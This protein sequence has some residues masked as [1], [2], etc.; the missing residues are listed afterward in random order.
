MNRTRTSLIGCIAV[1]SLLLAG[2][3]TSTSDSAVPPP[4]GSV[5]GAANPAARPADNGGGAT[6]ACDL[7]TEQDAS[8]AI[9][10]PA[11]PG[12]PGG[13]AALSECIF[14]DGS[15]IVSMKRPGRDL[16]DSSRAQLQGKPFL[17]VPDVGDGGFSTGS[18]QH[19]TLE[20]VKG[21]TLVSILLGTTDP[22]PTDAIIALAKAAV[23]HL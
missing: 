17:D 3:R 9:G 1:T 16:Y 22:S 13:T 6:V 21:D 15:L 11:G 18:G 14:D 5:P 12:T 20:F 4:A 8:A 19:V 2:C 10:S 7:I 23:A